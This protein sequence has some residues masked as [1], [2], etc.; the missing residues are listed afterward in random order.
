MSRAT[1]CLL[2]TDRQTYIQTDKQTGRHTVAMPYRV[3]PPTTLVVVQTCFFE[4]KTSKTD[5]QD[6]SRPRL[7]SVESHNPLCYTDR[8]TDRQTR[9]RGAVPR[10]TSLL[11]PEVLRSTKTRRDLEIRILV[12]ASVLRGLVSVSVSRDSNVWTRGV[13]R[14]ELRSRLGSGG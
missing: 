8:H 2:Q 1:T 6:V 12:A 11:Q 4:T 14:L 9:S 3:S 13:S 5:S 7:S 10:L